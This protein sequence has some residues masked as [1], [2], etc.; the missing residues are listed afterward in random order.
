MELSADELTRSLDCKIPGCPDAALAARGPYAG[1]CARH[2]RLKAQ[3]L[4]EKT[5]LGRSN[6]GRRD[7]LGLV[8][9]AHSVL[10]AAEQLEHRLLRYDNGGAELQQAVTDFGAAL[11]ELRE[12]AEREIARRAA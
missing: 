2:R 8:P 10:S 1:L 4:S 6:E 11:R 12:A 5:R 3:E 7:G 9:L